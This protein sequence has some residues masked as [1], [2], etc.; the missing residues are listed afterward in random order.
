MYEEIRRTIEK[1]GHNI[2]G[3]T[4]VKADGSIRRM[5]AR[6]HV[7]NPKNQPAPQGIVD[8]AAQDAESGTMTV[9][10]MNKRIN[11][12]QGA[13]RRFRLESVKEVQISGEKF[14]F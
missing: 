14:R 7:A 11:G 9:Y 3:V 2:F 10:D 4:F 6:L 5:T 8:R 12:K 13:Y 1:A